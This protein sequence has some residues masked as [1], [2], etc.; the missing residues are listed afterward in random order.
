VS[1]EH[2]PQVLPPEPNCSVK[3]YTNTNT[4]TTTTATTTTTTTTNNNNNNNT[5]IS[6]FWKHLHN[7]S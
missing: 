3:N 6:Y 5:A 2:K 7:E 1:P 4:T